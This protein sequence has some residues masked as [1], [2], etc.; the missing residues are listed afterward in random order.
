[1]LIGRS[2]ESILLFMSLLASDLSLKAP[3]PPYRESQFPNLKLLVKS[4]DTRP[5]SQFHQP[6]RLAAA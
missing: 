6:K 2:W 5:S 3:L 4:P 1:M